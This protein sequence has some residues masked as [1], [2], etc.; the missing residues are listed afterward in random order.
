MSCL[1]EERKERH[2]VIGKLEEKLKDS[3][4][5][6]NDLKDNINMELEE[7]S[8]KSS[9]QQEKYKEKENQMVN[10]IKRLNVKNRFLSLRLKKISPVY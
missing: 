5:E 1:M 2:S 6:I 7:L 9:F 3:E 4:R 10:E 8:R